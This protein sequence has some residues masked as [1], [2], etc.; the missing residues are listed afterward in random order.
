MSLV[1]LTIYRRKGVYPGILNYAFYGILDGG[2]FGN[3]N[4]HV[5]QVI[6]PYVWHLLI[7]V[8]VIF[9]SLFLFKVS[10]D[11]RGFC[12]SLPLFSYSQ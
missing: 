9:H 4:E 8:N 3:C 6:V 2:V 1:N 12:T 10:S 5:A 11:V 7:K